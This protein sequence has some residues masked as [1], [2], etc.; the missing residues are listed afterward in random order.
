M[1]LSLDHLD[2]PPGV[3]GTVRSACCFAGMLL[4][5]TNSQDRYGWVSAIV[6]PGKDATYVYIFCVAHSS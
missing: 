4:A 6:V 5:C 3:V 2:H 1:A